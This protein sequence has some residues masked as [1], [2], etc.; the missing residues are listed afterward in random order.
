MSVPDNPDA[1]TPEA[2]HEFGA[3]SAFQLP[4]VAQ[5]TPHP[6]AVNARWPWIVGIAIAA[7]LVLVVV[8]GAS[9][10]GRGNRHASTAAP[11]VICGKTLYRG[12]GGPFIY[13]PYSDAA[14]PHWEG[15]SSKVNTLVVGKDAY[16]VLVQ[17][18]DDCQHGTQ[19]L[20]EPSGIVSIEQEITTNTG[21]AVALRLVGLQPG[22][23]TLV[24]LSGKYQGWKLPLSVVGW[25]QSVREPPSLNAAST[26]TATT[27]WASTLAGRS[28][29]L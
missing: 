2:G 12:A 29:D 25:F 6:R 22:K 17:V 26:E 4:P 24:L 20:F 14:P 21:G 19:F 1:P 16:A 13:S 23:T 5:R 7:V 28:T 18:S 27:R 15:A 10:S 3:T 11:Y 8:V 9:R